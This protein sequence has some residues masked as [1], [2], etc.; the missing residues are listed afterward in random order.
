MDKSKFKVSSGPAENGSKKTPKLIEESKN[1]SSEN[2]K[3]TGSSSVAWSDNKSES[4][5]E[6]T[7]QGDQDAFL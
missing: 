7:D 6:L 1:D 4:K 3:H 2:Q 5:E